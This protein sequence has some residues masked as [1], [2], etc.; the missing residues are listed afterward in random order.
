[1]QYIQLLSKVSGVQL[2][3]NYIISKLKF[4]KLLELFIYGHIT[5]VSHYATFFRDAILK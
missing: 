4:V 1:M 5:I 2:N 3:E